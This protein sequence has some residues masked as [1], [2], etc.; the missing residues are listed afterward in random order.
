MDTY[1]N[2]YLKINRIGERIY[3]TMVVSPDYQVNLENLEREEKILED[4]TLPNG[5]KILQYVEITNVKEETSELTFL[6]SFVEKFLKEE[7]LNSQK[8]HLIRLFKAM[9]YDFL[10]GRMVTRIIDNSTFGE[11][12]NRSGGF[13][14]DRDFALMD[15]HTSAE[16]PQKSSIAENLR[17]Y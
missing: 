2:D 9:E 6:A 1:P 4:L 3:K 14:R 8:Q 17:E 16:N 10:H 7:P 11:N 12:Y 15:E 5:N 13:E